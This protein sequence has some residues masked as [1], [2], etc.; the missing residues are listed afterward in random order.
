[1]NP[2]LSER[3]DRLLLHSND[4]LTIHDLCAIVIEQDVQIKKLQAE[5]QQLKER[6]DTN[7]SY[8]SRRI[9]R[10]NGVHGA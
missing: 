6:C 8:L 4:R 1:M 3:L 5:L 2:S 9:D 7:S 10:L